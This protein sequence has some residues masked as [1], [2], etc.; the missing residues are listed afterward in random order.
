M[1]FVS[2]YTLLL[3]TTYHFSKPTSK[4]HPFWIWRRIWEMNSWWEIKISQP[5]NS[6]LLFLCLLNWENPS[7]SLLINHSL[8]FFSSKHCPSLLILSF[9]PTSV[10]SISFHVYFNSRYCLSILFIHKYAFLNCFDSSFFSIV[11][12]C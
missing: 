1:S 5:F 2:N 12:F 11:Q 6:H 9:S 4:G 3:Q 8:F 10:I 7:L